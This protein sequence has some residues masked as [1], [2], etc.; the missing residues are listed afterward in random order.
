LKRG[1]SRLVFVASLCAVLALIGA[2]AFAR[3]IVAE[4]PV[5]G[6]EWVRSEYG[7]L[8]HTVDPEGAAW[9]G[10][11]REGDLL[12]SVDGQPVADELEAGGLPWAWSPGA[13]ASLEVERAGRRLS[14]RLKPDWV[15]RTEPY[16]YLAL[17]GLA[18]FVS[19][20]FIAVRWPNVRG[21]RLYA[22]LA[23][24]MFVQLVLSHTGRADALDWV[25]YWLD[26]AAGAV[27]PALFLHF[28]LSLSRRT[29][30]VNRWTLSAVYA[31][32]VLAFG[33][34]I[35]STVQAGRGSPWP[36]EPVRFQEL[37]ER[38]LVLFFSV[39]ILLSVV[40]LVRSY[41]RSSSTLHRSQLRWLLWGLIIGLLPFVTFYAVPF[42]MGASDLPAWAEFVSVLPM[43]LAPAAFT[44][45]LAR[46]RLYD[47]S[48][49]LRRALSEVT[50]VFFTFA[51][52]AVAREAS[53]GL[54]DS[55]SAARY[56]GILVAAIAFTQ[57]R[58]WVRSG[59]DR[60]FY[61]ER[62]SYR[63]TLLDWAR[64][65][66]AETD[67]DRL[68]EL[69]TQRVRE[70]LDLRAA[71]VIVRTGEVAFESV[72]GEGP[73]L[74]LELGERLMKQLE[75]RTA[76]P[77]A[78]GS[79]R[80]I[81][82]ARWLFPMK[83][84]GT[85]RALL[86]TDDRQ[87]PEEPLSTEDRALL[88]T[89]AAHAATAIEAA[90]LV[91]EVRIRADEIERLHARQ[92]RIVESSAV[93]LLLTDDD[94]RIL[95]WNR[96]L[97][98]TYGL[99]RQQ[100]VGRLIEDVF[101]LH[102]VRRIEQQARSAPADEQTRLYRQTLVNRRGERVVANLAITPTTADP[103]A[104][105]RVI[106]FDDVSE[107]VKLEEQVF[108]QERLASLGLLA[109]G[110]AHEVNTPLT[111]ISSYT[112][113]LLEDLPRSDPRRRTLAKI[114]AQTRRAARI[115][116]SLLNL[117][118]PEESTFEVLMLNDAVRE[119]LQLFEPQVR[120]RE[121]R[122][123]VELSEGDTA[124]LGHKGKLQQVLLNLLINARDAV[125]PGGQIRIATR[126]LGRR[127]VAEVEDDGVGIAAED[128]PRIFD[129][130]FTTKARGKGTG[131]GLS[132]SHG[133]VEEHR[134]QL[135]ADSVPGKLTRFR[136]ELPA[137]ASVGAT[138]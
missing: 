134:G 80:G 25:V 137:A 91:R 138:A 112:Q 26:L 82:W 107:R 65:L 66:S 109:A 13:G 115:V 64:E 24:C 130:F 61:R 133:I 38:S 131:L 43:L 102:M 110:V 34:A 53:A 75:E 29:V 94:G 62:Y 74:R 40:A 50:A 89:L 10:G 49:L 58:R 20:A 77:V 22:T 59:V 12:L 71:R 35:G 60:A 51:V 101:P 6:A 123:L 90:R 128:L 76:V 1:R 81:G 56:V 129:P 73:G 95:A 121:L 116:N 111:G 100:A 3:R 9:A 4:R 52:Y 69:L 15:P 83:V 86:A 105:A 79:L 124:V 70:T 57:L 33:V 39:A 67:F 47:L 93:G 78:A 18:F 23:A 125:G 85:V 96:A 92:E 108:R 11:L 120:G 44:A 98:A 21:G 41:N 8:V 87:A 118:R 30:P 19:G 55:R 99:P 127:V 104:R 106:T 46:Y 54:F 37:I 42:A 135:S 48:L 17:V 28:S 31:P 88:G 84:K 72:N 32:A 122:L 45:A 126:R 2:L 5:L 36:T 97:E 113:L 117:A 114:E 16:G 103:G 7:V 119:T 14:L 132:I 68:L 27:A 136:V 63:A